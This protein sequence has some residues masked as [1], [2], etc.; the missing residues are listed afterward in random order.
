MLTILKFRKWNLKPLYCTNDLRS[1]QQYCHFLVSAHR[2]QKSNITFLIH[3]D[4]SWGSYVYDN[5]TGAPTQI[6]M[7]SAGVYAHAQIT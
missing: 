5:N 7:G 3:P 2:L 4:G 1:L 6:S